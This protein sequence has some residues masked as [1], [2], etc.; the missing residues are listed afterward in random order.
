MAK[1]GN[2]LCKV[3]EGCPLGV[4]Q[5]F[6]IGIYYESL[7]KSR[8]IVKYK[9]SELVIEVKTGRQKW[10]AANI[11]RVHSMYLCL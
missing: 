10:K 5:F 2:C 3:E 7:N 9:G 1:L 6:E 8:R 11:C 4:F